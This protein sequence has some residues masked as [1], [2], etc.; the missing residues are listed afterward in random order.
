MRS[1]VL[2]RSNTAA[3]ADRIDAILKTG[4]SFEDA[5]TRVRHGRDYE[6]DVP[7]GLQFGHHR[8][9]D[10]LEH[11]YAFVVPK[12]YD[13]TRPYQ[14]RFHLHGG[15]ARARPAGGQSYPG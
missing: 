15:I 14:V 5:L 3:A 12:N 9:F 8:T 4:V 2:G 7:R 11:D 1:S 10:S 13:P 6:A